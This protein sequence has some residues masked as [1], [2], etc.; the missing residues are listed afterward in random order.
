LIC[1]VIAN[2]NRD[3][4]RRPE[5]WQPAHF[6]PGAK[7]EEDEMQEF[8]EAIQRG[9]TFETDPEDLEHFKQQMQRSFKNVVTP[10]EVIRTNAIAGERPGRGLQVDARHQR[11]AN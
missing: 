6:M 4:E 2:V 8:V 1:S 7:S 11:P 3:A 10:G 5:P 9:D